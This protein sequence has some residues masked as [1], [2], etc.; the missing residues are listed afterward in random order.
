MSSAAILEL[1]PEVRLRRT[2]EVNEV[3]RRLEDTPDGRLQTSLVDLAALGRGGVP[4]ARRSVCRLD[5]LDHVASVDVHRVDERAR[6]EII[7]TPVTRI[8]NLML[9]WDLLDLEITLEEL[10]DCL[11]IRPVVVRRALVRLGSYP[12]AEVSASDPWQKVRITLDVE[13]CPLTAT[14]Q[15]WVG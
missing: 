1:K 12:G 13:R 11:E 9:D 15:A 3:E 8:I 4:G 5:R 6:F 7:W 2:L 14:P 10:S